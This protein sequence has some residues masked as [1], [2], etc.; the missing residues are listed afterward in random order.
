[1][2]FQTKISPE[3]KA[4]LIECLDI[5]LF[6]YARMLAAV[7][8]KFGRDTDLTAADIATFL[9]TEKKGSRYLCQLERD[10]EMADW[11]RQNHTL[12]SIDQIRDA[13]IDRFGVPRVPSRTTIAAFLKSAGRQGRLGDKD[14]FS[15][16][17]EVAAWVLSEY[18]KYRNDELRALCLEK[19]GKA[20]TPSQSGLQRFLRKHQKST[21]IRRHGIWIDEE[22]GAWLR[23]NA[24]L[25]RMADLYAESVKRFGEARVGSQASIYR[26]L[27]SQKD[28]NLTRYKSKKEIEEGLKRFQA[29]NRTD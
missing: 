11:V 6:T 17:P 16:K 14:F 19:F 25:L 8:V 13:C 27:A 26:F 2:T 20:L 5:P 15:D 28:R 7:R 23:K 4:F 12:G 9:G 18:P 10:R 1:M 21:M 22:L 24:P 29:E 3:I